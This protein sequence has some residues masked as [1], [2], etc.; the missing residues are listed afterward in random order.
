MGIHDICLP[1]D[2]PPGWE[3]RYYN[4][5]YMLATLLLF[6]AERFSLLLPGYH[7][8]TTP[9]LAARLAPLAALPGLAGLPCAGSVFWMR[10]RA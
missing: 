8:S 5:Q 9:D 10:K 2:Y 6:G 1:L 7:V 4:E 3:G